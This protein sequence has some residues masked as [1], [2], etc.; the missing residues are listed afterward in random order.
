MRSADAI[1]VVAGHPV[2]LVCAGRTDAGV[3]ARGQ[4]VH[5]DVRPDVDAAR[6]LR[7]V[8]TMLS[9]AVVVRAA[10]AAAAAGSTPAARPGPGATGT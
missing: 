6:L 8:N 10:E 7:S 2:E 5:V 1:A 9:P 3:H 4:V